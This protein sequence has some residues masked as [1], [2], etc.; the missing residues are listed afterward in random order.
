MGEVFGN[1]DGEGQSVVVGQ[2]SGGV[3]HVG[4]SVDSGKFPGFRVVAGQ[5]AQQVPGSASHIENTLRCG[6]GGYRQCGGAVTDDVVQT[7]TPTLVVVLGTIVIRGDIAIG[8]HSG[9]CKFGRR[10]AR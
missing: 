8:R 4:G 1:S 7:T 10:Y 6:L 9:N 3:D 2:A 5:R